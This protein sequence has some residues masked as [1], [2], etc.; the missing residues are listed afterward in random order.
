MVRLEMSPYATTISS[1]MLRLLQCV[2]SLIAMSTVAAGFHTSELSGNKYRLGSHETN[3]M[4]LVA[5]SGML[6]SG[7]YLGVVEI[8]RC[9][10]R[11]RELFARVVDGVFALFF[12]CAAAALVAS[13]YVDACDEYGFLLQCNNLKTSVAFAF[14]TIVPF[15][16]S[17]ALTFVISTADSD[18]SSA[19]A[20][21]RVEATPTGAMSPLGVSPTPSSK[22]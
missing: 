22:V 20:D 5:Y 17:F 15:L 18:M 9:M 1:M 4:L 2:G 13:D 16:L 12:F 8:S 14:L 19:L 7:W 6:Y 11:P 21:Y 10:P 3:F